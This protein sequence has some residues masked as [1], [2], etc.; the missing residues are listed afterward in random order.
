MDLLLVDA[1]L[2]LGHLAF[3]RQDDH[4]GGVT[5]VGQHDDGGVVFCVLIEVVAAGPLHH[6]HL[7]LG[8][9][10]HSEL[11]FVCLVSVKGFLPLSCVTQPRWK[12]ATQLLHVSSNYPGFI[13]LC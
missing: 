7:D 5:L 13:M 9:F 11:G 6:V 12:K 2:H 10:V 3:L 4:H 8:V 1:A